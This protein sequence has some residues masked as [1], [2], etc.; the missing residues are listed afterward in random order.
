[1]PQ[2]RERLFVVGFKRAVARARWG[3]HLTPKRRI[4]SRGVFAS[5]P[6]PSRFRGKDYAVRHTTRQT[7]RDSIELTVF[8]ALLGTGDP[9]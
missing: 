4:G 3:G 5:I 7:T 1:V 6:A 8:P 9:S 2:D